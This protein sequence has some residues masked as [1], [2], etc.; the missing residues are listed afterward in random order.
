MALYLQQPFHA[1]IISYSVF[2]LTKQILWTK[3]GFNAVNPRELKSPVLCLEKVFCFRK[4][5][6]KKLSFYFTIHFFFP[7][8]KS[9]LNHRKGFQLATAE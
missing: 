8:K 4:S 9:C 1:E 6:S 2:V 7:C 3:V 5:I